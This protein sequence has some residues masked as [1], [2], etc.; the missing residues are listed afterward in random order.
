[1]HAQQALEHAQQLNQLVL[2]AWALHAQ[3]YGAM[4]CGD[5]G[6]ALEWY[7][8]YV[9][10]V[11]DTENGVARH[12]VMARA[13]EAYFLSGRLDDAMRLTERAIADATFA[14]APH[15]LA[16]ARRV[17]GQILGAQKKYDGAMSA[18]DEAIAEFVATGSRLELAR[19]MYHRTALRFELGDR[20]AAR[21]DAVHARDEFEAVDAV[22]D[23]AMAEALLQCEPP[24]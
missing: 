23:R 6:A 19:A 18:F 12:L 10:L 5:T 8:Q 11:R 7:E 24:V 2:S 14:N 21:A 4:Q 20:D 9:A 15:Y 3:G 16:L 22:R 1:M 17:Q 13:A